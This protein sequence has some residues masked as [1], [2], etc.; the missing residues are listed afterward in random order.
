MCFDRYHHN[1][2]VDNLPSAYHWGKEEDDKGPADDFTWYAQGFPLGF[3]SEADDKAYIHN[4]VS[5]C[6]HNPFMWWIRVILH[7]RNIVVCF[8]LIWFLRCYYM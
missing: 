1:W 4:H 2:I 8:H 5:T 6:V 7:Q 3:V